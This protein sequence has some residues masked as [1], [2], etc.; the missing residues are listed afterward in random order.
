MYFL[1]LLWFKDI[2]KFDCKNDNCQGYFNTFQEA[3][4]WLL[5]NWFAIHEYWCNTA[6]IEFIPPGNNA[7]KKNNERHW[8]HS[9]EILESKPEKIEAPKGTKT[10]SRWAF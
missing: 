2:N 1:T 9:K 5:K 6:V 8:Y 7:P 10:V 4:D 3:E